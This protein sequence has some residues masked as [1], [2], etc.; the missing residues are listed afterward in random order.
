[1]VTKPAISPV[2]LQAV[3]VRTADWQS[4]AAVIQCYERKDEDAEWQVSGEMFPAAVGR[5]G[6]GWGQ[7]IHPMSITD[8]PLKKEGDEKSPAGIF[9][10]G[11]AFG[12]APVEEVNWIK[13]PYRQATKNLQCVDDVQSP[14]YN[15]IVDANQVKR[16]WKSNEDLRRNDDL[17]RLAVVVEHNTSPVIAEQGSC[18]FLHI[19]DGSNTGTSGCTVMAAAQLEKL[20]HWLDA[21]A[22]PVLVQLPEQE[23]MRFRSLWQLP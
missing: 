17:Y 11:S 6:M 14:Y 2:S 7:G 18:I 21:K 5:N 13:L 12:Y 9:M 10:L 4:P 15:T 22:L 23:Y 1:M 3:V 8:G 20:L 19:W 16:T